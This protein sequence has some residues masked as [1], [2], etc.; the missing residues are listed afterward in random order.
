MPEI[1]VVDKSGKAVSKL[2]LSDALF[3]GP[4]RK[5]LIHEAVRSLQA[6]RRQG[7][8]STKSRGEVRGG[9]RKPW[10]QKGTGR[11]RIGTIRA[12]HWKGGGTVFGP[13]PRDYGFRMPKKVRRA[14]FRSALADRLQ[15]GALVVVDEIT[16]AEP[17][18]KLMRQWLEGVNLGKT[19]LLLVLGG[20]EGDEGIARAA[21]NLPNVK[22]VRA[23]EVNT[24]DVMAAG[25]VLMPSSVLKRMEEVYRV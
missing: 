8:A 17:K 1:E 13:R 21:R 9:G 20:G 6:A 10:R 23:D 3:G 12:P 11:A 5:D 18:T 16:L 25:V 2:E 24:L 4:V 15:N 14:A 7:T 19:K 22:V